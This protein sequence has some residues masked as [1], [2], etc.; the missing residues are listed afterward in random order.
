MQPG[1]ILRTVG[2][3]KKVTSRTARTTLVAS[4][5]NMLL[6]GV[7]TRDRMSLSGIAGYFNNSY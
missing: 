7:A 3:V 6:P 1:C 2:M 5:M 4:Q